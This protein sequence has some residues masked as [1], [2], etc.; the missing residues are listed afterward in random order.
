MWPLTKQDSS[1]GSIQANSYGATSDVSGT[2][3]SV[4]NSLHDDIMNEPTFSNGMFTIIINTE[5]NR[6]KYVEWHK[7][8]CTITTNTHK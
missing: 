6:K 2:D 1:I 5:I 7:H 8:A 3:S 4:G